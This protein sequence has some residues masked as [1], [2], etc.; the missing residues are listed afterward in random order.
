MNPG[1]VYRELG[2]LSAQAMIDAIDNPR[3][4]D[5]RRNPY[6]ITRL[7]ERCFDVWLRSP[8]TQN[9]DLSAWLAFLDRVPSGELPALLERLQQRLWLHSKTLIRDREDHLAHGRRNG[10]GIRHEVAAVRS[11]LQ[12]KQSI[13]AVE[14]VEELQRSLPTSMQFAVNGPPR[15]TRR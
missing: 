8:A 2:K 10:C 14:F 12:L 6:V 1:N 9:E 11:L 4:A 5:A 13:A 15:R 7:G 3:E